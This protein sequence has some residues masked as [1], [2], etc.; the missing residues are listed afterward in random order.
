MIMDK[1]KNILFVA[2]IPVLFAGCFAQKNR[3]KKRF[4]T[5]DFILYDKAF[6]DSS[7]RIK[8]D[9]VYI[10]HS[11]SSLGFVRFFPDGKVVTGGC[12]DSA[13]IANPD[14]CY[15]SKT[16]VSLYGYYALRNDT[17]FLEV[18]DNVPI[19]NGIH[20]D[21]NLLRGDTLIALYGFNRRLL[22]SK[23]L[24]PLPLPGTN[25]VL[26]YSGGSY[27]VPA[28]LNNSLKLEW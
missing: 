8:Y 21:V 23:S 16:A 12:Y 27:F 25:G 18:D 26:R 22:K 1:L 3:H 28:R 6:R 24:R 10:K 7:Q 19:S 20:I 2:V 15:N 14:I 13:K 11:G 5:T 17:V 9:G 4:R